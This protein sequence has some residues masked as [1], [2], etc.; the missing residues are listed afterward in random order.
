MS[1]DYEIDQPGFYQAI[2]GCRCEAGWDNSSYL[3]E[4]LRR[5]Q[6]I[7]KQVV[8]KISKKLNALVSEK[9]CLDVKVMVSTTPTKYRLR[10]GD[11]RIIFSEHKKEILIIVIGIGHRKEVYKR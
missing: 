3:K 5:C 8:E 7:D 4:Y 11:Y 6:V 2:T 9:E 10:V 1:L